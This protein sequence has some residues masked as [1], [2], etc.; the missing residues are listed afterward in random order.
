MYIFWVGCAVGVGCE[1][2]R[3]I[4]AIFL[5]ACPSVMETNVLVKSQVA[6]LVADLQRLSNATYGEALLD[7]LWPTVFRV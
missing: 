1:N 6:I 4:Q 5:V 2:T 3:N 7:Y